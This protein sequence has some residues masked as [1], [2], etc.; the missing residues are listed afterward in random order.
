VIQRVIYI[1]SAV[2]F[3]LM[4]GSSMTTPIMPIFLSYLGAGEI[5]IGFVI[6]LYGLVRAPLNIPL[7]FMLAKKN[8]F[9]SAFSGLVLVVLAALIMGTSLSP[10]QVAIGKVI[11]GL[12][13]ILYV[14]SALRLLA[15]YSPIEERGGTMGIYTASLLLGSAAGPLIGG[16]IAEHFG[17]RNVFFTYA[18]MAGLTSSILYFTGKTVKYSNSYPQYSTRNIRESLKNKD[19]L[20]ASYVISSFFIVR[21]AL[22]NVIMP[23][24]LYNN[25]GLKESII[26]TIISSFWFITTIPNIIGGK[27]GDRI[28]RKFTLSLCLS[29]SSAAL[30][31]MYFTRDLI[32]LIV[33]L[34][35]LAVSTGISGPMSAIIIDLSKREELPISLGVYRTFVD[36]SFFAGPSLGGYLL[37][38]LGA[39]N[40]IYFILSGYLIC[41]L[42][43]LHFV[44]EKK[45]Y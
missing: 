4:I 6:S 27:L 34:M 43:L 20:L 35:C 1:L 40:I 19:I 17:E 31:A 10:I 28:G 21:I 41:S 18:C 9:K 22:M 33:V 7:S 12:G 2:I 44:N 30:F 23:L 42:V 14:I 36:F 45:N 25:Y 37:D 13:I 16:F 11:E 3:L 32:Q 29:G 15:E 24:I 26:G 39:N 38:L 8:P 5:L